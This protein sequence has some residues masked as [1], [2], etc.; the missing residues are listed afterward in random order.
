M[1][2]CVFRPWAARSVA[3]GCHIAPYLVLDWIH[4]YHQLGLLLEEATTLSLLVEVHVLNLLV[5]CLKLL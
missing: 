4:G 5:V 3:F 2:V 1:D